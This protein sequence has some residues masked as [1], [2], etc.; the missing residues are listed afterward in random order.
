[1]HLDKLCCHERREKERKK[2]FRLMN[3]PQPQFSTTLARQPLIYSPIMNDEARKSSI[4]FV[5]PGAL[6]R[7]GS[8]VDSVVCATAWKWVDLL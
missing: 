1:M 7:K 8:Q 3:E 5:K 6:P 2:K 4:P